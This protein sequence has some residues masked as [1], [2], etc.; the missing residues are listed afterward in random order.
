[1]QVGPAFCDVWKATEDYD[2]DLLKTIA[3]CID[4]LRLC[5]VTIYLLII[6][7]LRRHLWTVSA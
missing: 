3:S 7:Y 1:M 4:C 5:H 6:N 2:N